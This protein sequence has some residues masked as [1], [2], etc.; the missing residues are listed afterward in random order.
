M[1]YKLTQNKSLNSTR[2]V[3]KTPKDTQCQSSHTKTSFQ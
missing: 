1:R 2:R 3:T